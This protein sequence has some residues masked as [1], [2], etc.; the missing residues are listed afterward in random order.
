MCKLAAKEAGDD[1]EDASARERP[2][3]MIETT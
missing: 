2:R 1:P 3:P